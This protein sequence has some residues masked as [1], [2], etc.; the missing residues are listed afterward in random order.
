VSLSMKTDYFGHD[1]VY[2][3]YK[4]EGRSDWATAEVITENI[5]GLETFIQR[6][7]LRPGAEILELCGAGDLSMCIPA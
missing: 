1:L 7:R 6:L 4:A 3:Q 2:K 5:R